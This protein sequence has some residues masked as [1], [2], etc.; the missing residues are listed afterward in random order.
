MMWFK[1]LLLRWVSDAQRDR[2]STPEP[3]LAVKGS[4]TLNGDTAL[5]V[6]I[7][8]ATNG[9]ILELGKF[10][11]NPRGPDWTYTHYLL[12]EGESLQDAIAVLL[13]N[14]RLSK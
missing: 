6:T 4:N 9:H 3:P 2:D 7:R 5:S 8:K 1:K 10:V 13:V 12:L 14:E 11:P